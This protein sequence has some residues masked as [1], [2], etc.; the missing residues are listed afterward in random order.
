MFLVSRFSFLVLLCPFP[1]PSFPPFSSLPSLPSLLSLPSLPPFPSLPSFPSFPS[2]FLFLSVCAAVFPQHPLSLLSFVLFLLPSLLSLS[3]PRFPFRF[4][5]CGH[6]LAAQKKR[7]CRSLFVVY[8]NC[9]E[10]YPRLIASEGQTL[11]HVPHSVHRSASI[12]YFSP[13]EI[14]ST[15]HSP[16]HVPHA[17]QSSPIT[18]AIILIHLKG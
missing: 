10:Y 7:L 2:S 14:A 17:M 3:S 9:A 16:A 11:A 1:L 12:T 18:Y 15:G 5:V 6:F 8:E 4:S 13:S